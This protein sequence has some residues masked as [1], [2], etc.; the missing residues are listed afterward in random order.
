M[1]QYFLIE[2]NRK[3]KVKPITIAVLLHKAKK[4][5]PVTVTELKAGPHTIASASR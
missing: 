1:K 2:H 3:T 5:M 4:K